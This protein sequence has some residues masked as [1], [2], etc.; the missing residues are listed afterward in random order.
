MRKEWFVSKSTAASIQELVGLGVL[1]EQ[2]LSGWR[3]P[4]MEPYP[5]PEPVE[6]MVFEDFFKRGFGIP[7]HPFL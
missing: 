1:Q 4:G 6:I 3:A 7:V 2:E 5:T